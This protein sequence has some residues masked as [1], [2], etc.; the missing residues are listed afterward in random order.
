MD[1]IGEAHDLAEVNAMTGALDPDVVVLEAEASQSGAT[2][3]LQPVLVLV[4][5]TAETA[6]AWM[7]YTY[8]NI[9][10]VV[11]KDAP[12]DQLTE[13]VRRASVGQ[14]Y[15]SP[16]LSGALLQVVRSRLPRSR[17]TAPSYSPLTQREGDVLNLLQHGLS[18][19]EI[20]QRLQISEKTVKYHV[21]NVLAKYQ[22]TSRSV[23]IACSRSE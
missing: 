20:A 1:V 18:N 10:G 13:A 23:L 4:V 2:V 12:M 21:S 5:D 19:K 16:A 15:I 22:A 9:G 8:A 11:H 14:G 3:D 17:T 7:T 6:M